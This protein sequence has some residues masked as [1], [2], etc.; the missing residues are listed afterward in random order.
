VSRAASPFS[1][2]SLVVGF[3]GMLLGLT[4]GYIM[5]AGQVQVTPRA[6]AAEADHVHTTGDTTQAHLVNEDEVRAFKEI[7]KQDPKNAVAAIEIANRYYDAHRYPEAIPY[8][9]QALALDTRNVAVS[10]DLGTALYYAGLADEALAQ[11]EESLRIDPTHA[12]TYFNL[13][14]VRRDAKKDVAGAVAAWEQLLEAQPS[15]PEAARV[16]AL[17]DTTKG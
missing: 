11:F 14:L 7:L 12:Q 10:T 17:I 15:Y 5:G 2:M 9:R 4:T 16:R 3:S 8:Y 13:G 1:P 6:M